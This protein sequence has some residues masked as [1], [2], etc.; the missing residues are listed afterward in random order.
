MHSDHDECNRK[1]PHVESTNS[2]MGYNFPKVEALIVCSMAKVEMFLPMFKISKIRS[3]SFL[4]IDLMFS[5]K[6]KFVGKIVKISATTPINFLFGVIF[7]YLNI[8]TNI[9][10]SSG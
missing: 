2:L 10:M 3:I 8:A 9:P 6:S 4:G 7:R 1:L 5:D